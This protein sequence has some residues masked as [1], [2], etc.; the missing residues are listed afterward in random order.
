MTHLFPEF[1]AFGLEQTDGQFIAEKVNPRLLFRVDDISDLQPVDITIME[2]SD[3]FCS[4]VNV[5]GSRYRIS[6][7]SGDPDFIAEMQDEEADRYMRE[8]IANASRWLS[9][10]ILGQSN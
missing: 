3:D 2:H 4:I 10:H 5:A 9:G 7:A 8:T 6:V 1:E